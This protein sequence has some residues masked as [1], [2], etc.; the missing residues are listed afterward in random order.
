MSRAYR[1]HQPATGIARAETVLEQRTIVAIGQDDLLLTVVGIQTAP[2]DARLVAPALQVEGVFQ[3]GNTVFYLNDGL[4]QESR[5]R[6]LRGLDGHLTYRHA[7]SHA[8]TYR[9]GCNRKTDGFVY[10]LAGDINDDRIAFGLIQTGYLVVRL[11]NPP[12]YFPATAISS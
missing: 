9:I 6:Q 10:L 2:D 5:R 3:T 8:I 7:T 11:L 4:F 12:R 1:R